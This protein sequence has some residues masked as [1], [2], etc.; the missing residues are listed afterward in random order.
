[1]NG[2][3]GSV[4]KALSGGGSLAAPTG[5]GKIPKFGPSAGGQ[6]AQP[7]PMS[8]GSSKLGGALPSVQDMLSRAKRTREKGYK[9][10]S[11]KLSAGPSK[12]S[13]LG[14]MP[15]L[16]SGGSSGSPTM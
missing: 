1:M 11:V 16:P 9:K 8:I 4:M 5:K 15:A 10:T 12:M 3:L 13:N 14:S 6:R 7:G 2:S